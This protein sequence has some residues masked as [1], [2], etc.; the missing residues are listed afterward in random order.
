[1]EMVEHGRQYKDRVFD[2]IFETENTQ[3]RKK[4]QYMHK[5]MSGNP[6]DSKHYDGVIYIL[7]KQDMH[8]ALLSCL[9]SN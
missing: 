2:D 9:S 1:M 4:E 3:V 8:L 7:F 5:G 6:F